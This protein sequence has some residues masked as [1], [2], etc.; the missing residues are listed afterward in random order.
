M[1]ANEEEEIFKE[2]QLHEHSHHICNTKTWEN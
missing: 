2:E 1:D